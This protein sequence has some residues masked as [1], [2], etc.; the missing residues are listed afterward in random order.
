MKRLSFIILVGVLVV[1]AACTGKKQQDT[2]ISSI[3]Y[4]NVEIPDFN[5][6]SAYA[7][8]KRQCDFGSRVPESKA[9]KECGDYLV[10]FFKQFADT[11]IE[12]NFKTKLYNG[13][14]VNGRN[15]IISFNLASTDRTLFAAHWDSRAWADNDPDEKNHKTPIIG[16][17]DG[18]S[19]VGVLMEMARCLKQKPTS[20]G[21]DMVLFDVEDQGCPEWDE[22][23]IEDQSDWCLGAQFWSKNPHIPFYQAK[24]GI[25]LDMV[26][27]SNPL[28]T[29]ESQSMYYASSIMNKVWQIAKDKG[30]GNMFSD[31]L[32]G[33][34]MDDH[35]WVNRYAK[36]PMIDIV[37]YDP[38]GSFF[39]YWHTLKDDINCISK[40]TLKAVGEV[41]LVAIYSAS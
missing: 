24:Y 6:D 12:Q 11:V 29:K 14:E 31:E 40:N 13:K 39:P 25:L 3:T 7:Y 23:D 8:V 4:A 37:Q 17:N 10:S 32:T 36:I 35:V 33:G 26:G 41:C 16:A 9:H 15:I 21:I 34:V 28:F 30:Y 5:A 1:F 20:L 2:A 27:Y 38:M 18:A 22:T 19:G